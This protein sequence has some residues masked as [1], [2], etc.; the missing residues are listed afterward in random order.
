MLSNLLSQKKI[1]KKNERKIRYFYLTNFNMRDLLCTLLHHIPPKRCC[2]TCFN[3]DKSYFFITTLCFTN[4]NHHRRNHAQMGH[5]I[6][7]HRPQYLLQIK[8]PHQAVQ[9]FYLFFCSNV[10]LGR[11]FKGFQPN[12]LFILLTFA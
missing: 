10:C 8:L 9:K 6:L 3:N 2:T 4:S 11:F 1:N 12:E 7:L 5:P